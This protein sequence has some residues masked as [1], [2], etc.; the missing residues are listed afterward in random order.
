MVEK[1]SKIYVA[2]HRGLVGSSI[3]RALSILGFNNIVVRTHKELDLEDFSATLQFFKIEK[4]EYVIIAAAKVGGINANNIYPVE[5][6]MSNLLVQAN[7][8]RAAHQNNVSRLLFL[9]SSCIYPRE[10]LQPIKESYLLTGSLEPTNR[11]Y[12][13]SK[14]A[15]IEMC[16][17]YNRQYSTKWLSAM[18]TNTYGP[19]DNY[20]LENS[21]VMSALIRKIHEAK[22]YNF[23]YVELW[24]SG[25]PRREFIYVDDLALALVK[26]ITLDNKNYDQ[27]VSPEKCPIINIGTGID[28]TIDDLADKIS[29]I[30]GYKGSF[31]YDLSKPDGI[32]QKVL[33]VTKIQELGWQPMTSL[34]DG[35]SK[36]Y[37][38]YLDIEKNLSVN[39]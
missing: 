3:V 27:L 28:L 12:A 5:F 32:L 35:I 36:T 24:G 1:N 21:H 37:R 25:K 7:I 39:K 6:L 18:P 29:K 20:N 30:I 4:P 9:G 15:G 31:K 10:C 17:S 23:K 33:D 2:G 19:G 38:D 13:L 14:I 8:F 16:W 34:D 26:L 11:P 22:I